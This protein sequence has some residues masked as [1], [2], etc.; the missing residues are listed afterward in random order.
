MNDVPAA[1]IK[2]MKGSFRCLIFGLLALVPAIGLPFGLAALWLSGQVRLQEKLY[3]NAA[4]PYRICGMVC[5]AIG[6]ILWAGI[7]TI[8]IGQVLLFTWLH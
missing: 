3:W 4:K 6:T 5:G 2:M 7:A 8:L 1:K